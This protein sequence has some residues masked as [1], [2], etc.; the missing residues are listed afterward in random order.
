MHCTKQQG[1]VGVSNRNEPIPRSWDVADVSSQPRSSNP[2]WPPTRN[3]PAAAMKT[4]ASQS[5]G[6][7]PSTTSTSYVFS[8]QPVPSTQTSKTAQG[9]HHS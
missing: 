6:P 2:S 5:T 3:S 8:H 7:A 4:T 9:G 1:K